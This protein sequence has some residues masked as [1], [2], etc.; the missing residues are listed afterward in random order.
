MK[1]EVC[2]NCGHPIAPLDYE[3]YHVSEEIEKIGEKPN[4]VDE[5]SF[6]LSTECS[7]VLQGEEAEAFED[8]WMHE[9]VDKAVEQF[10]NYRLSYWFFD[11]ACACRKPEK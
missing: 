6:T 1:Y 5:V 2:K 10:G 3:W 9:I 7:Y 11:I 8:K 4:E